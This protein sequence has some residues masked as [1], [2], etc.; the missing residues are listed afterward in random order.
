MFPTFWKVCL[1]QR[2]N[3]QDRQTAVRRSTPHLPANRSKHSP[4]PR[5]YASTVFKPHRGSGTEN[6]CP[7]AWPHLC[8][9]GWQHHG[10]WKRKAP[11]VRSLRTSPSFALC[12]PKR[13]VKSSS[14]SWAGLEPSNLAHELGLWEFRFGDQH[15]M[16]D[17]FGLRMSWVSEC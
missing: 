4:M 6:V 2:M 16:K 5:P 17:Y 12:T 15:W 10:R 7:K 11:L 3:P 13:T 9:L 14:T 1:W 8:F